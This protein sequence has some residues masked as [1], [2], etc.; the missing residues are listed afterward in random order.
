V[1]RPTPVQAVPASGAVQVVAGT[2]TTCAR[3]ADG[4]VVCWG[5]GFGKT[6][7]TMV[8]AG[9]PPNEMPKNLIADEISAGNGGIG[10]HTADGALWGWSGGGIAFPGDGGSNWKAGGSAF[11]SNIAYPITSV[12]SDLFKPP[13]LLTGG[14]RAPVIGRLHAC[15]LQTGG[16]VTCWG[17][18]QQGQLGRPTTE[19]NF[20]YAGQV[21]PLGP[22][23]DVAAGDN[24]T[25][26]R[27]QDGGVWCW[28]R[29][30]DKESPMPTQIPDL[31]PV[32][33]PG[34]FNMAA[35]DR[36]TCLTDPNGVWC[37][38]SNLFGQ[39]GAPASVHSSEK[40]L[41]VPLPC[42]Q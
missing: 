23:I 36:H 39:L 6:G 20:N 3:K 24:H 40:P 35:G 17:I 21:A 10:A 16:A 30:G 41:R 13:T 22:A 14:G 33:E 7:V 37:W 5:I 2:G 34:G 42:P 25:C 28:G 27:T 31:V 1:D 9:P 38:G 4:T 29:V 15:V 32:V 19:L 8:T 11:S 26:A 18:N 12:M